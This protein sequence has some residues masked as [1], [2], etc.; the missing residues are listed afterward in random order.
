MGRGTKGRRYISQ[1]PN[2]VTTVEI[3]D[4][5][6]QSKRIHQ[7]QVVQQRNRVSNLLITHMMPAFQSHSAVHRL[8]AR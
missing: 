4:A 2:S 5:S 1:A 7:V 8:R 6:I 3:F